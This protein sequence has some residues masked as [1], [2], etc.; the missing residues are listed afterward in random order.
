MKLRFFCTNVYFFYMALLI[1]QL[2]IWQETG[3]KRGSDMQQRPQRRDSNLQWGQ[4]L[5]TGDACST[6]WAKRRSKYETKLKLYINFFLWVH[7][8]PF[9]PAVMDVGI[10]FSASRW[11]DTNLPR[12]VAEEVA[13]DH[14]SYYLHTTPT[15]GEDKLQLQFKHIYIIE[16]QKGQ[17][18]PFRSRCFSIEPFGI[19]TL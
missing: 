16:V 14:S 3:W 19:L 5:C 17:K 13:V 12:E 1:V 2:K 11:T 10:L 7:I 6:N 8:D 9:I 15:W 4:Y 18:A